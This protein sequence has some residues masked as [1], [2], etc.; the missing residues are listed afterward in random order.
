MMCSGLYYSFKCIYTLVM[1][2]CKA[3]LTITASNKTV[4]FHHNSAD[5]DNSGAGSNRYGSG[6]TSRGGRGGTSYND[7]RYGGRRDNQGL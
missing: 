3:L 2:V 6:N 5:F 1:R 7:D 4:C